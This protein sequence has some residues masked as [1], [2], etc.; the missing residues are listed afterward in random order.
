MT[1]EEALN[2]SEKLFRYVNLVEMCEEDYKDDIPGEWERRKKEKCVIY[3]KDGHGET[4][5]CYYGATWEEAIEFGEKKFEPYKID[6]KGYKIH[7]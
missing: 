6:K 1:Q 2:I 4:R 5:T 7:D 3:V